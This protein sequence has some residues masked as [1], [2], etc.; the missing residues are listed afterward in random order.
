MPMDRNA[1][2]HDWELVE[3]AYP[4]LP[5]PF[6]FICCCGAGVVGTFSSARDAI[7]AAKSHLSQSSTEPRAA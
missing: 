2:D 5:K 4:Q 1:A 7:R 6:G 3:Q